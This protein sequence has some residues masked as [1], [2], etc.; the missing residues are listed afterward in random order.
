MEGEKSRDRQCVL[1]MPFWKYGKRKRLD[2]GA[3]FK[4]YIKQSAS[5]WSGLQDQKQHECVN[6][7]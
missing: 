7:S 5:V 2:N 6:P 1:Y 4:K 3:G